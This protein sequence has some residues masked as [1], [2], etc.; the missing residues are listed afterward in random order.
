MWPC[1]SKLCVSRWA[2]VMAVLWSNSNPHI[3]TKI[4]ALQQMRRGEH[5]GLYH[6]MEQ[7]EINFCA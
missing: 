7:K 4:S 1:A 2:S 3:L 5:V 6:N